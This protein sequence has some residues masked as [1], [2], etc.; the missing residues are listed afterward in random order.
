[1]VA[2]LVAMAPHDVNAEVDLEQDQLQTLIDARAGR[3]QNTN[4]AYRSKQRDF[5]QW[6]DQQRFTD[7]ITVTGLKAHYFL[8]IVMN[9]PNKQQRGA[10]IGVSSLKAHGAAC[11]DLYT[12][13]KLLNTN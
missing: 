13:Q 11:N 2:R 12:Q 6:M 10:V 8:R 3:P 4:K 7:E 9:R 1:M 5:I